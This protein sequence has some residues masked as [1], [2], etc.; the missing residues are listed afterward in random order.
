MEYKVLVW[1]LWL[2]LSQFSPVVETHSKQTNL[3]SEDF[4][5]RACEL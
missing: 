1:K 2:S 3:I 4:H 5:K